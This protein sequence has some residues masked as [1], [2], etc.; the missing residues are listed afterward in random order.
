MKLSARSRYG[1]RLMLDLAV[2]ST[3]G[4]VH[5]R[6]V[7]RRQEIGVK[8]LEQLAMPLK[9]AN[10]LRGVRGPGGG[11]LLGKP[12]EEI[13]VEG[14]V[15]LLEHDLELTKCISQPEKCDRSQD[16]ITRIVWAEVTEAVLEKLQSVSLRDLMDRVPLTSYPE[17]GAKKQEKP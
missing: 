11:Y 6:A 3:N 4:P 17:E 12:P 1:V 10:Y 8:Y 16:C 2:H 7:A 9:K 15:R 14:V 13:T 5:L